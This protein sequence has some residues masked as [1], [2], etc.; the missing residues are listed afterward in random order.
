MSLE[1]LATVVAG[2]K[3][4]RVV[5]GRSGGEPVE[6]LAELRCTPLNPLDGRV[7]GELL[8][9]L[10]LE[11]PHQ[12]LSTLLIGA[13]H[14]IRLGDYLTVDEQDYPIRALAKWQPPKSI[15]G[16]MQLTVEDLWH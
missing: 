6:V 3:R 1:N 10:K 11:T 5:N 16:F 15:T 14:D 8:Q 7:A 13:G 2:T 9:R 12:L 4:A